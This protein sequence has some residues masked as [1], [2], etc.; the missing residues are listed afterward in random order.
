[1]PIQAEAWPHM[2]RHVSWCRSDNRHQRTDD[3]LHDV[4]EQ[5]MDLLW[6]Q[7]VKFTGCVA[8]FIESG[9]TQVGQQQGMMVCVN[10]QCYEG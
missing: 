2:V 3:T 8:K 5:R 1:M 6:Y 4:E 9:S 10:P 7:S